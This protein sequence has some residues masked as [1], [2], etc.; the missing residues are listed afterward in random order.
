VGGNARIIARQRGKGGGGETQVRCHEEG[1]PCQERNLHLSEIEQGG[2][3]KVGKI[4]FLS[5]KTLDPYD[6][7]GETVCMSPLGRGVKA[8]YE[9]RGGGCAC[10]IR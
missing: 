6:D 7:G 3:K 4:Y 10:P 1:E 9:E 8:A 2:G 5:Q